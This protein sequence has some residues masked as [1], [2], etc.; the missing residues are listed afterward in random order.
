[1]IY[2]KYQ[3]F[4]QFSGSAE[5]PFSRPGLNSHRRCTQ[6]RS[7]MAKGHRLGGAQRP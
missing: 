5:A 3:S 7:R 6:P 1:V 4:S 2:K